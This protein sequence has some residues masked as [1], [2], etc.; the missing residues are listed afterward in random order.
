MAAFEQRESGFWQAKIRRKGHVPI[1]K[2]FRSKADAEAWARK[3]ESELERGLWRDTSAVETTT[4]RDLINTYREKELPSK[5]GR[6]FDSSLKLLDE[7]LGRYP[8]SALSSKVIADFR[9]KQVKAGRVASVRKELALLSRMI[10][11]AGREWGI[12][13][14]AN[15]CKMVSKPAEGRARDRR[16][17]PGE[18]GQLVATAEDRLMLLVCVAVETAARLGELLALRWA[19]VDQTTM[20]L[21]GIDQRGLK[22]GDEKRVVPLSETAV[23]ALADL[24]AMQQDEKSKLSGG[25]V[26]KLASQQLVF[27]RYWNCSERAGKAWRRATARAGI[28]DLHF[29]DLRH[30]ATSRLFEAGVFDVMEVAAITGHKTLQMLKRYTHLKAEKLAE[31]MRR[32]A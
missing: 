17:H 29:H 30:E 24:K 23:A 9:D 28:D 21:R 1:S 13:L 6:H 14:A 32:I 5:R 3:T 16:L 12:P 19:D 15:P 22:N 18:L 27:G 2:S 20:T 10:D 8:L 4:I 31:K 7:E 25:K 26:I 11:L